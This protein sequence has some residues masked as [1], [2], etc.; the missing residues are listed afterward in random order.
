MKPKTKITKEDLMN[1][2]VTQR[3]KAMIEAGVYNIHK[4]RTF[5]TKKDYSRKAKHKS[6]LDN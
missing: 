1:I 2:E 6:S 5:K 4:N 3:R